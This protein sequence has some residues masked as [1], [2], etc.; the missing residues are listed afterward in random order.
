MSGETT[1]VAEEPA[2]DSLSL[3]FDLPDAPDKVWKALTEPAIV[4]RWIVPDGENGR[5]AAQADYDLLDK[6]PG[7]RISY[8]WREGSALDSVVTFSIAVN[9]IGGTRLTIVHSDLRAVTAAMSGPLACRFGP[10][11]HRHRCAAN[12]NLFIA[13]AA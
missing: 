12:Q 13:R 1:E 5:D 7:R 10:A 9:A 4:A 8:R 3:D 11:A 6:Q 2:A